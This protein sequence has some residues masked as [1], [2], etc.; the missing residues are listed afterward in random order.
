MAASRKPWTPARAAVVG[1]LTAGAF[2]ISYAVIFSAF[3]HVP[4][5]YVPAVFWSGLAVHMF[6]IGLPM[7][8][9]ASRTLPDS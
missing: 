6:L 7:A 9:F 4:P 3:R 2:D 5:N 8:L 1:G